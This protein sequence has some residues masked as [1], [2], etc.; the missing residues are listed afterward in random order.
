MDAAQDATASHKLLETL[1]FFAKD[2]E[3][4]GAAPERKQVATVV[5]D[6]FERDYDIQMVSNSNGRL[7]DHYPADIIILE[8][9]K[10]AGTT[11]NNADELRAM[12]A[13]DSKY[14]RCRRRFVV[15]VILVGNMNICR[16]ATLARAPEILYRQSYS[17]AVT[18]IYGESSAESLSSS[19]IGEHATVEDSVY[20]AT[21]TV[22]E[23]QVTT[24][25]ESNS[26]V[27]RCRAA[28]LAL[29]K[30]LGVNFIC[31]LMIEQRKFKYGLYVTSSEKADT[32]G[33]YA[34]FGLAAMPY[35]GVEWFNSIR[36][37]K[38]NPKRIFFNWKHREV[39]AKLNLPPSCSS[40]PIAWKDYQTWDLVTLTQA[41]FKVLVNHISGNGDQDNQGILVHCVSGWDRTPLFISLLRLSLWAD[42]VI[43]QSLNAEQI[44]YLTVG[45]DWLLF[46]HMLPTRLNK[47]EEIFLFCF[48]FLQYITE[49]DYAFRTSTSSPQTE[50][51]TPSSPSS[52]DE[53]VLK[54]PV[55]DAPSPT[56]PELARQP[57][58]R[59]Q[60]TQTDHDD[61]DLDAFFPH[62]NDHDA[63]AVLS[64][65]DAGQESSGSRRDSLDE[66]HFASAPIAVPMREAATN[67]KSPNGSM[68]GSVGSWQLVEESSSLK[69]TLAQALQDHLSVSNGSHGSHGSSNGSKSTPPPLNLDGESKPDRT[70]A[71]SCHVEGQPCRATDHVEQLSER[72]K[73]LHQVRALFLPLYKE[74]VPTAGGHDGWMKWV[75]STFMPSWAG[76]GAAPE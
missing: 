22:E 50:Q 61:L 73:R 47:G 71:C 16:S 49:D 21:A 52:E 34:N 41:Y 1:R 69:S 42:G 11:V 5:K 35:P 19:Q 60:D 51:A 7:C 76:T 6:L 13:S 32:E 70:Y 57:E 17:T 45:Y 37:Q 20:L 38:Y 33:R 56:I 43:H 39:S 44:L 10:G 74:A 26:T 18:A 24:T 62:G 25:G 53:T 27:A 65:S 9:H 23:R 66:Q 46:G 64:D 40:L 12:F 30:H 67:T 68:S 58:Q 3:C 31:D 2:H 8:N 54:T 59:E 55:V 29:L 28:D 14:A 36:D 4:N 63:A 15:P 72:S 48:D 75:A